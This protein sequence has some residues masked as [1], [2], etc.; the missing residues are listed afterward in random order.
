MIDEAQ[1][2]HLKEPAAQQHQDGRV[3]R[4]PRSRLYRNPFGAQQS[5]NVGLGSPT[6]PMSHGSA[7]FLFKAGERLTTRGRPQLAQL[8][9]EDAE[10]A[11]FF[12]RRVLKKSVEPLGNMEALLR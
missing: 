9:D 11:E 2:L 5:F 10:I 1:E 6:A 3:F 12:S 8:G 7:D 4:R